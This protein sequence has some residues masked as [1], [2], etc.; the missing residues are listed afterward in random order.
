MH[1]S[2]VSS[3]IL[4]FA[5]LTATCTGSSP[6][7]CEK[8]QECRHLMTAIYEL[9]TFDWFH[10]DKSVIHNRISPRDVSRPRASTTISKSPTRWPLLMCPMLWLCVDDGYYIRPTI[11]IVCPVSWGCSTVSKRIVVV[12]SHFLFSALQPAIFTSFNTK[13]HIK[14]SLHAKSR[15]K[16][17]FFLSAL[18]SLLYQVYCIIKVS[19]TLHLRSRQWNLAAMLR[20]ATNHSLYPS[21][22]IHYDSWQNMT[23]Y[24]KGG[25]RCM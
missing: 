18:Q 24:M 13:Q 9:S 8:K 23:N 16:T 19:C 15:M 12:T 21:C 17:S 4:Y 1:S 5:P 10:L 22:S 7:I 3:C 14:L 20:I 2:T 6:S 11:V 25:P